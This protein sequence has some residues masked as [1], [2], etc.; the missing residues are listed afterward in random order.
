M[1]TS[2]HIITASAT[3][4]HEPNAI[5]QYPR[6]FVQTTTMR[7]TRAQAQAAAQA[8]T[9]T[10]QISKD[11]VAVD[12]N[13]DV[14]HDRSPLGELA[15]N[16]IDV[17]AADSGP[18]LPASKGRKKG[19]RP[20]S[21]GNGREVDAALEQE[22]GNIILPREHDD[23][24]LPREYPPPQE[25]ENNPLRLEHQNIS[26]PQEHDITPAS[27]EKEVLSPLGEPAEIVLP[28]YRT[29]A[30]SLQAKEFQSHARSTSNKENE[31]PM[32]SNLSAPVLA[33]IP[34]TSSAST[35]VS[36]DHS[37]EQRHESPAVGVNPPADNAVTRPA[38]TVG[39]L[40]TAA[41]GLAS[42][43]AKVQP[44]SSSASSTDSR[45]STRKSLLKSTAASGHHVTK[46]TDA[47]NSES[48]TERV[49]ANSPHSKPRK[50]SMSFPPP[51]PPPPKG[52]APTKSNF[53]LPGE[54]VAAKLKAAREARLAKDGASEESEKRPAFKARP[55]PKAKDGPPPIVRETALSRARESLMLGKAPSQATS[56]N[57][58]GGIRR[59]TSVS[60]NLIRGRPNAAT[61]K[62]VSTVPV[63]DSQA[64]TIK[65]T[66]S[67]QPA[68]QKRPSSAMIDRSQPRASL[69]QRN[70][71]A[72]TS[73][74]KEVF[75]RAAA[76]QDILEKQKREKEEAARKARAEAAERGRIASREWAEKMR[77][78]ALK[79]KA[80]LH[81]TDEKP[82]NA[83]AS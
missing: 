18:A 4:Q 28:P 52:R 61:S 25:H 19:S 83:L 10:A 82:I 54:V 46:S 17:D 47:T 24:L 65:P 75:Q 50:M 35:E 51:P 38:E 3:L 71:S 45:P 26:L 7:L 16:T 42:S 79:A 48:K 40:E 69:A 43:V 39:P 60:E 53:Q 72:G 31:Q 34:T 74:G 77:L 2:V 55:V 36:I 62:R 21:A 58:P 23:I 67:S 63:R 8:E 76:E 59:M 14:K 5:N 27:H 12:E 1:K 81:D 64:A 78:K 33:S 6:Y 13:L 57:A 41:G 49:A 30:K 37:H 44:S 80:A 22:R 15:P 68:V 32:S 9:E 70:T 29:I 73:K 66:T 11:D 20:S 56:A